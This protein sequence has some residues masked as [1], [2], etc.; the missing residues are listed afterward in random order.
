MI[1]ERIAQLRK[2]LDHHNHQYYVLN[3]PLVSDFEFDVMMKELQALEEAHP[4]YADPLSPTQRVGSD[5]NQSFRQVAHL[6]PMLSLANTYS[7][8][9]VRDFYERVRKTLMEPFELVCELKYDG[10]SISLI[11]EN[12]LLLRAVTRGDGVQ[13]DDVT[14]NVKTIRSIPLK[15]QGNYPPFFEIRGE[16]LMPW[17][18]FDEI[19]RERESREEPLFAN[20]RNAGS[21]TLKL[22]NSS[23]VANRKLD[24]Y[25]YSLP[26]NNM[27]FATHYDGLMA[28]RQWGFK[29]SDAVK[30]CST[31]EEVF[32]FINYFDE[33]RK[34]L[35]VA[36]DGIVIKVNSMAQ[37]QA[38]G[39]TAK[40][41]RWAIAY[42]Y[43][44]EKALTKLLSVSFQVGRTGAVTPVANLDP[45]LLSGTTVKRASLHNADIIE[46]LDLHLGD[47]VYV[48]KGGEIIPKITAVDVNHRSPDGAR[49]QF[50][51]AC[52][53][54]GST[55]IRIEGEAAHYCPNEDACPPQIKGKINHFVSRKA[56]NIDGLGEETINLLYNS[57][58]ISNIADIYHLRSSDLANLERLGTKSASKIVESV[59]N[60]SNVPFERVLFALGIRFVGETVAKK[61]ATSFKSI[62]A[63]AKANMEELV[64]VDEIGERIAGSVIAYISQEQHLQLISELRQAGL[65]M[66]LSEEKLKSA[67]EILKGQTIVIS[68]T[69]RRYSR[70]EYKSMIEHN[71]GKN[72]GSVS[73]KTSFILAGEN[74]GPEKLKKAESLGVKLI[75]ENE[76]LRMIEKQDTGEDNEQ[77]EAPVIHPVKEKPRKDHEGFTGTLF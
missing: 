6:Y 59:R 27:A 25:F 47:M 44:A 73:A 24:S 71:G 20:P 4:E 49:V 65:Q 18:V 72:A 39:F 22:Q 16:I 8:G 57:G 36:T 19:N 74:M 63:L 41:P 35:P 23:I 26:G 60:S 56:M 58:L 55:L 46:S 12:G 42:K 3:N 68:G 30:V 61:L 28:A 7:E 17:A 9:E 76:F 10:T 43:Q 15:L 50:I 62:D 32:D 70:D 37:Q 40:S 52:P 75:N 64:A 13:G 69:F 66:E 53:E 31:V 1:A 45:V 77:Q 21:G 48:E 51:D 2:E 67:S 11:Y 5:I 14:S 54:C 38:L 33:A 29:V 34:S